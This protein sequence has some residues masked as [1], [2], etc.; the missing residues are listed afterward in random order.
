MKR[1]KAM[2]RI[3]SL[4]LACVIITGFI[5]VSADDMPNSRIKNIIYMIPDGGGMVPLQLANAVKNSGGLNNTEKYPYV[6]K[7]S[8]G[9]VHLLEYLV[10][11]IT[12]HSAD[13]EITDSAAAGTALSSGIK[14][15]NGYIGVDE[16][17]KPHATIL[18]MCQLAGKATGMVTTYDWAN[19]TP[20]SFS[21]HDNS[22]SNNGMISEQVVNQSIDV[23]LGVGFDMSGG[24]DISEAKKRGYDIINN[25]TD[26]ASV[27]KG[28]KIWGNLENKEF[29]YDIDNTAD[30]VTLPEMTNAA[31]AALSDANENGFFLMVEGSRVDGAGHGNNSLAMVGDFLAFDEAFK[32]AIDYAKDRNDTIVIACPDHDTGGMILPEDTKDI[33]KLIQNREMPEEV[34]WES[35]NHTARNGGLFIYAPEGVKLPEDIDAN[36]QNPFEDNV[37]DNTDVIKY[38]TDILG[39]DKDKA[40]EELFVDVTEMGEY[41]GELKAFVFRDYSVTVKRN[42]SYAYVDDKVADLDGQ[43]A[44][45][46]DGRF[47]VPQKL[48]DILEEKEALVEYDASTVYAALNV[49]MNSADDLFARMNI[50]SYIKDKTVNGYVKFNTPESFAKLGNIEFEV[51]SDSDGCEIEFDG[52]DISDN[53][54]EF[55]YDI[56]LSGGK[57]YSYN[58]QV[59]G[60]LYG[61]YTDK[62]ITV[63]GIIDEEQW[64]Y[65][66]KF[67]C[68][69]VSMLTNDM[70]NWK[71]FRDLSA[72]FSV[73]YDKENLYFYATVTDE[74]FHQDKKADNMWEADCIQFGFYNDTEK[75]Y[76]KKAAGTRYDGINFGFV[77]GENVAYRSQRVNYLVDKG[78]IEPSDELEFKTN[79]VLNDMTYEIKISWRQLLGYDLNPKSGDML[80]FSFLANDNDGEGR[81]GAIQYGSGIYGGKNVNQFVPLY[82]LNTENFSDAD[83]IIEKGLKIYNNNQIIDL[84]NSPVISESRTMVPVEEFLKAADIAY[85]KTGEGFVIEDE[86]TMVIGQGVEIEN[87]DIEPFYQDN[88]LYMPLRAVCENMGKTVYWRADTTGV[89]IR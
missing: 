22:R 57:K 5:T 62:A 71:G 77:G 80:A 44:V 83:C 50:R 20:A 55:S 36:S 24:P 49:G 54:E 87:S 4:I 9:D 45:Y 42:A 39:F 8:Q 47:Y 61:A 3:I 86:K 34:K 52:A 84:V 69:D 11:A 6:T 16:K 63:D 40:T 2:K 82:L 18:E 81:R 7:T 29:P 38:L 68:D 26:L 58:Q 33:V 64:G 27:K 72:V 70:E 13:A 37:I 17:L 32:I 65:A 76:Q 88:V 74:I 12:T 10:G 73:L 15:K 89:Y 75:L 25:R 41:D 67:V 31:I 14:T 21:A 23:V 56:V 30:T 66:P 48:F 43:V 35:P 51:A 78:I 60:I 85:T 59:S 53:G 46:I 79:R 1:R 28:D 19:A